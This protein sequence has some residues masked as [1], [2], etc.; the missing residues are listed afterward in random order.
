MDNEVVQFNGF[1]KFKLSFIGAVVKLMGHQP[2]Q[3]RLQ[4]GPVVSQ[5]GIEVLD[6]VG[7]TDGT[8]HRNTPRRP[9]GQGRRGLADGGLHPGGEEQGE[10]GAARPAGIHFAGRLDPVGQLATAHKRD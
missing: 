8:A 6:V 4:P 10:S 1:A 9:G 7:C 3:H 5:I 2:L